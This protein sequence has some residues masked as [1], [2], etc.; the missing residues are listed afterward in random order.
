LKQAGGLLLIARVKLMGKKLFS[1]AAR[2][3]CGGFIYGQ[4]RSPKIA[5]PDELNGPIAVFQQ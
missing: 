2:F 3:L 4:Q 1:N 5:L